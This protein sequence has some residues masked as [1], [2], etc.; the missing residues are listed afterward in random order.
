M[1]RSARAQGSGETVLLIEDDSSVRLL[2]GEV[3][4]DL[5]YACIEASEGQ[6]AILALASNTRLDL[7]ITNVGLQG[8]NGRQLAGLA[9]RHRPDMQVLSVTGHAEQVTGDGE[10]LEFGMSMVTK[11]FTLDALAFKIREILAPKR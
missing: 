5:G 4:R 3:L 7:M 10:F 2:I 6:T 9:R 11:P 1:C 8:M